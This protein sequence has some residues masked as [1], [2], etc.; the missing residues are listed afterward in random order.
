MQIRSRCRPAEVDADSKFVVFLGDNY[1][2]RDPCSP[3]DQVDY[4]NLFHLGDFF[5]DLLGIV[6]IHWSPALMHR[7]SCF[8][9]MVCM[10]IEGGTPF[11]SL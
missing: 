2:G 4:A 11:M 3:L 10:R 5:L 1:D 8:M 6:G 7:A 9:G